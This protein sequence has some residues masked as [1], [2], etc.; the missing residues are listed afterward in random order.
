VIRPSATSDVFAARG[1]RFAFVFATLLGAFLHAA[2]ASA[3]PPSP[4]PAAGDVEARAKLL[5][6]AVRKNDPKKA[7]PFFFPGG[8]F[9][10]VKAIKDPAKYFD[11]LIRVYDKDVL[12]LR[13][14]LTSPDTVEFVR[15]ELGRGRN[16]IPNFKEA[17]KVPYYATYKSRLVVKDA[18]KEKTFFVRVMI[19][20]K[21]QWYC[22][23][24]LRKSLNE[25]I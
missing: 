15:F 17:N 13:E 14:K 11:Y 6:E 23:H 7:H 1:S 2:P 9:A 24:L 18:G 19:S 21:G 25:R 20:W 16:W 5:V 22:T 3:R 4:A 8:D 12:T 10:E